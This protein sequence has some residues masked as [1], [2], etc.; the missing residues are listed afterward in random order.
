MLRSHVVAAVFKRNFWSYFS[1][2]LG[3]LFIVLYVLAGSMLAFRPLFFTNNLANLAELN[4]YFPMLLLFIVPAITM[5]VWSEEKKLGTDELLF[6]L[7]VSDLEVLIGKYLSVV[8]VYTVAL[9]F[10]LT[11][12]LVL[13][14]IGNPDW[15][16]LA[17]TYLGYWLAGCALL[18]AGMVASYLTNN[19]TVAFALGAALCAIPVFIGKLPMPVFLSQLVGHDRLFEDLSIANQFAPFG[20]G[21]APLSGILYFVTFAGFMLYVNYVLIGR[22]HWAGGSHGTEM[23][24]HYLVRA[25]CV[26][27]MLVGA[28]AVFANVNYRPDF[29][30]ER[31]FTVTPVTTKLISDLD[32]KRPVMIQAFVSRDVPREYVPVRETLLGLLA[33]YEQL[34]RGK[35]GVRVVTVEPFSEEAD[36]AKALGIDSKKVQS[37]RGGRL[38]LDDVFLGAVISSGTNEVVIPF[39]EVAIP[40]EYELTRS[41]RTVAT[42]KRLTVGILETDAKMNGG[43]DMQSFRSTPEWKI[44]TELKKQYTVE[45]VSPA[46]PLDESKYD[47]VVAVLPSSLTDRELANFTDYVKK[48]KPVLIFDDPLPAFINPGLAPKQPKQKPG[49]P[50]GGGP[51]PEQKADGGRATS[52]VNLLGIQWNYDEIVWDS[53]LKT[54]HPEFADVVREEMI[55]ISRESGNA[56]AFSPDSKVTSGLQEL[57]AFFSGTLAKREDSKLDFTP[58]LVTGV[59][60]GILKWDDLVKNSFFGIDI[61]ENPIR[62]EDIYAHV[63]AAQIKGS[64]EAKD[65]AEPVKINAIY[66]ADADMI[67]DIFFSIRER[68]MYN[69]DLDNV[70]FV[71]NAIDYLAGDD[72]YIDLRKRRPKHRTLTAVEAR[73]KTFL[74]E[75]SKEREKAAQEAKEA[76]DKRKKELEE[77]VEKVKSDKSLSEFQKIQQV[78]LAQQSQQR[79]LEVEEANINQGKEKRIEKSRVQAERHVRAIENRFYLLAALLPPIPAIVL[80]LFVWMKRRS[81]ERE[82]IGPARRVQK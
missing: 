16:L 28:N 12:A 30:S 2:L 20:T 46:G 56:K 59:Q 18:A 11:H 5:G 49:G 7:P 6:T 42:E 25:V 55:A 58:L 80:G 10:S 19:A 44:V 43:F 45:P 73:T 23:G 36:Q 13:E 70:T 27:V 51:P 52:L 48:G 62:R 38:Q 68:K 26:G 41:V 54:L 24:W 77:V 29:T 75:S 47:V 60:S 66:V 35:I 17:T 33:Q 69:L 57:L 3:Y 61:E 22:R 53:T 9:I 14:W 15:G 64:P 67:F 78:A 4:E 37:E 8:A 34:G 21:V 76:L 39:F 79:M 65:G 50:M 82:D 74:E 63:I 1:G 71:L 81:R 31:L 40:I 32:G 72:A